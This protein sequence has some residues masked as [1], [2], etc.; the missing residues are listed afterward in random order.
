[1]KPL[2]ITGYVLAGLAAA[3]LLTVISA[4]WAYRDIPAAQLEAIY[5]SPAS[6]FMNIDG[7]RIHFRDEGAGPPVVLVH[8][9]FASLIGWD[10]WVDAL[11]DSYRV[12]RFDMTSHGLTGPDPSGDYSVER[13]VELTERLIDALGLERLS[14]GGTSLGGT[15]AMHYAA[16]HPDRID[17]LILLSPGAIAG[18]DLTR[19]NRVGSGANL[20]KYVLPRSIPEF[21]LRSGFGDPDKLSDELVDRWH[22]MWLREGQR[23]AEL[24]RLRQY[25]SGDLEAMVAGVRA[26]VL[27]MWGEANSRAKVEQAPIFVEMLVGAEQVDLVIYPGVGHMAVQEAGEQTA[28]DA[29][30]YLDGTLTIDPLPVVDSEAQAEL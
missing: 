11:Q 17:K 26:P 24:A 9:H 4:L 27:I 1:M 21:M 13:T 16:R 12:I 28:R 18:R 25:D 14:I 7:V 3:L 30:A 20:L 19:N 6:R 22:D 5:A 2:R 23:E 29:R 10:P 8:A 15:V